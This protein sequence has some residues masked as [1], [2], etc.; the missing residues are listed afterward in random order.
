MDAIDE[1]STD[2]HAE[3]RL[4]ARLDTLRIAYRTL[5]HAPVHSVAEAKAWRRTL[6]GEARAGGHCKCLFL[7]TKKGALVL[8][9]VLEDRRVDLKALAERLGMGRFSFASPATMRAQLGVAPGAVT[10]FAL[11]NAAPGAFTLVLD[12]DMLARRPLHYHP[13]HNRATMAIAPE[14][15]LRFVES[16]GFDPHIVAIPERADD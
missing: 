5:R 2:S 10:P 6:D 3:A 4:M 16:C 15:L 11:I 14:D 8:A 7:K 12:Q 9:V 1:D 13:L